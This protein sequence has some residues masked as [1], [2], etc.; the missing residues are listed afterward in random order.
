[1]NRKKILIMAEGVTLAHVARPLAIAAVYRDQFDIG[2]AADSRWHDLIAMEGWRPLSINSLSTKVFLDRIANGRPVYRKSE[3][4]KYIS[5]DLCMLDE[6][7]PDVVIGDFRVSLA[8]S[9]R[10]AGVPYANICN[11][12]WHPRSGLLRE[13]PELPITRYLGVA[14]GQMLFK[15]FGKMIMRQH[16]HS[17]NSLRKVNNI[18]TALY[19]LGEVYMDADLV[20]FADPE[21][22]YADLLSTDKE[23]FVG[24]IV[25]SPKMPSPAWMVNI[26]KD[27]PVVFVSLGSSGQI[28]VLDSLIKA[29]RR[30]KY[31][32]IVATAGRVHCESTDRCFV[33]E[34]LPGPVAAGIADLVIC[35]GGNPMTSLSHASGRP[36]IG[37]PSN[38]DQFLNMAAV[39]RA[40]TGKSMRP[41]ILTVMSICDMIEDVLSDAEIRMRSQAMVEITMDYQEKRV[42]GSMIEN[43]TN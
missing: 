25:W 4:S 10:R 7:K 11:A 20:A 22:Y 42:L 19:D 15:A 6:Y 17:M 34:F 39:E 18:G 3:L 23:R 35:N 26:P 28:S 31:T 43:L 30:L 33:E 2:I 38:M 37:I 16:C 9:A 24:P 29:G 36:V 12:Y 27:R 41:E 32:L 21:N 8:I 13:I 5:D 40:K 14:V 1:M